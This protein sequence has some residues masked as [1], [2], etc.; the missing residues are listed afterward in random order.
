ML[1]PKQNR[2]EIYSYLFKEGVLVVKKDFD[3]PRHKHIN[4][5]N[6]QVLKAMQSLESRGHVKS[7]FSWQW[8]YYILTDQ[9]IE[10][11]REYLH[12]PA[13]VVPAT[14]K[15]PAASRAPLRPHPEGDRRGPRPAYGDRDAYRRADKKDG[16]PAGD[17]RP[18][19]RGGV[20]RGRAPA[21]PAQQ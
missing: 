10:Y 20:G 17:Y 19:F 12:L 16:A 7:Q 1:I 4:V 3:L 14:F 21:A 8:F 5:P 9:G 6:L 11:L 2:K 13:E 18:E 15:K